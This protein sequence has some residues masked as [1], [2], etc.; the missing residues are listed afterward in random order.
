[1]VTRG[2]QILLQDPNA[3]DV[4]W[5]ILVGIFKCWSADFKIV[6]VL[7]DCIH[8]KCHLCTPF[9]LKSPHVRKNRTCHKTP[10]YKCN[11]ATA[12][13]CRNMMDIAQNGFKHH[14]FGKIQCNGSLKRQKKN[15]NNVWTWPKIVLTVFWHLFQVSDELCPLYWSHRGR[16]CTHPD[17]KVSAAH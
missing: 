12:L 16:L 10:V 14:E 7:F 1:M 3:I 13:K 4:N 11:M 8:F 5:T 9:L 2:Q 17:N 15:N 6:F